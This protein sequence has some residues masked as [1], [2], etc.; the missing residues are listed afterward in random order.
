[1]FNGTEPIGVDPTKQCY[2]LDRDGKS[3]RHILNF[4]RNAE[5][6]L[7]DSYTESALLLKEATFFEIDG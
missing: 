4:L 7:P 2:F 6:I 3:F 5:L 1:M